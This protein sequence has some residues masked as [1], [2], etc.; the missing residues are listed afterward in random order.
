[1]FSKKK[2]L[3]LGLLVLA[4]PLLIA[5]RLAIGEP[6][7][8]A[9]A[10]FDVAL[11]PATLVGDFYVDG[12]LVAPGANN[13]RLTG[14]PDADHVV[15]VRN[16]QEPG[17]AGFGDLYIYPDQNAVQQTHAGWIWRLY[18]YPQRVYIR[19][20]FT[21]TC[22]PRGYRA[23][24]SIACRPTIDGVTMPDVAPNAKATYT[25]TPGEHLVHTD[26]VGDS[27]GNWSVAAREDVVAVVGGRFVYLT[28]SFPLKGSLKISVFPNTIAADIYVNGALIA[29]QS[30]AAELFV[31]AV[32][33][34][35]IEARN[36]T[37]PAANGNWKYNDTTQTSIAY[38]GGTRYIYLRPVKVWLTGKLSLYCY[39]SRYATTDDA[40]CLVNADGVPLGAVAHNARSV[41]TLPT[42]AHAIDV[43]VTGAS[44]GRWAGP[45][46]LT[47][48]IFGGGTSYYTARFNLI[49]N[50]PPPPV[51]PPPP[52]G[53]GGT[54][55]GSFELG[56]QVAGFDR[57]DLMKFA[58][59]VWVKRQVRWHPG[60]TANADVINDAHAKGFKILLSVLGEP[61]S[62]AGG[63]NYDD[64]ARFVGEL[65][66]F[67]ADGIEV[68][69]EMN[70]DR[71]W[72]QGEID[73]AKYTDLLRRSYL[74]IK[75]S[76]PNTLVISGAPAPTGAEG[77]FGRDRV[78]NDDSFIAGMAAA[79]A[80]AYMDCIGA[81]YNEG[82]ISPTRDSGDPRDP[83]YTRYYSGMVVTY[84]NA[85]GRSR[86]IC[87]TELGYLTP[88]GYGP[89]SP[90]FG[91]AANTTV[92]QQAL[93]LA[94]AVSLA[95]S[96]S[97]VRMIIVFNV[98]LTSYGDDPQ[99][100]YAMIRPGGSC[101]ACDSL[102]NVTGGR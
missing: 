84:Y 57:P 39:L 17:V 7:D 36:V 55:P 31:P 54:T 37:D 77:A 61:S 6:C 56:G 44:A 27:A 49:P 1:M 100:G 24:D 88:E 32:Q 90:N 83:Y 53:G 25:L 51:A 75:A 41:F 22:L 12:V 59:M 4:W 60:D 95:R 67:G 98:D 82:I 96:S 43:S 35:T 20:S 76:N 10:C 50:A 93:W 52:G 79:G 65:A 40:A 21:Y 29:A 64:Y 13:A 71:E 70:I 86:K 45:L 16:L 47:Q 63:A 30:T 48:N 8:P 19:G 92:A 94:E 72:P 101:P 81:H 3:A 74:K 66:A 9:T 18:F 23:T 26:L 85:F 97:S 34:N 99:A 42:G 87:F 80:G 15:E 5:A 2:L 46:S 33:V 68:W 58:G 73:P 62:I 14:A 28:S 11:S 91:W 38:E 78:W 69:N 89:L 102:H